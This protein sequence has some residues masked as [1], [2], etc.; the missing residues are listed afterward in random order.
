MPIIAPGVVSGAMLALTLSL[1]D[2]IV[3]FFTTGIK[4]KTFPI[5]IQG[6]VRTGVSPDVYALSTLMIVARLL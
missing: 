2:V 3:S 5:Q 6:M 4:S 1:D